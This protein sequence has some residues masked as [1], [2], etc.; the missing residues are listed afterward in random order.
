MSILY[1]P[2]S[3]DGFVRVFDSRG[4]DIVN[5]FAPPPPSFINAD[6]VK[7]SVRSLVVIPGEDNEAEDVLMVG[8]QTCAVLMMNLAG[9]VLKYYDSGKRT[10]WGNDVV[11]NSLFIV[12]KEL[13]QSHTYLK[14][15]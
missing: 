14:S 7:L 9:Q 2:G 13:L 6:L 12:F 5:E 1:L 3:S 15:S 4:G 11:Y 8:L 10:I